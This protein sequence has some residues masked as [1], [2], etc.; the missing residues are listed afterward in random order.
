MLEKYSCKNHEPRVKDVLVFSEMYPKS[1]FTTQGQVQIRKNKLR[2]VSTYPCL[3]LAIFC[4]VSFLIRKPKILV[5]RTQTTPSGE[6]Q[7]LDSCGKV[8]KTYPI[9]AVA[10]QQR[11][12][13]HRLFK[14][15]RNKMEIV[16]SAIILT[17]LPWIGSLPIGMV[18]RKQIKT[19]YNVSLF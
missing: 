13:H 6:C 4:F 18:T 5:P 16:W 9:H 17:L 3:H 12:S 19:W 1:F 8:V 7:T 10:E 11:T 15:H 2:M 14:T